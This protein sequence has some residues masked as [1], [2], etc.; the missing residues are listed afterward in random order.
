MDLEIKSPEQMRTLGEVLGAL[1]HG[2]EVIE[3]TGDVGAGKTTL[4]K[5]IAAG[6]G[7]EGEIQSPS[8]T[9]S[10][11]YGGRDDI[12]FVHY[13]FYRLDKSGIMADELR[14][15]LGHPK[16]V[17]AI[18]WAGTVENVLPKDRLTIN[19]AAKSENE[20]QIKFTYGGEI[21]KKLKESL[22]YDF[23]TNH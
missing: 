11:V 13:D 6:L 12:T 3:L 21:S 2:G 16:T 17:A 14:E 9:I 15:A 8:F 1:M 23:N 7:V 4:V 18:E 19:I 10:R 22:N 20:R 5:G